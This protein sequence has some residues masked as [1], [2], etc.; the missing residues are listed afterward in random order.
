MLFI[1]IDPSLPDEKFGDEFKETEHVSKEEHDGIVCL[2][3][4]NNSF[5]YEKTVI[6]KGLLCFKAY[7]VRCL[8]KSE[9]SGLNRIVLT[10]YAFYCM[11]EQPNFS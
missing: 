7:A 1:T 6:P 5:F 9:I 4:L 8:K 11:F 3:G 2:V 10:L